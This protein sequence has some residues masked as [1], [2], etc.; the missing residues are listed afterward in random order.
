[1]LSF[2]PSPSTSDFAVFSRLTLD[3]TILGEAPAATG[4]A[5]PGVTI[6][7]I[8]TAIEISSVTGRIISS[9]SLR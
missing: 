1:M 2:R 3:S 4:A 5:T 6:A 7:V 9:P 8:A